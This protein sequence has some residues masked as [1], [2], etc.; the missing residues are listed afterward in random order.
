MSNFAIVKKLICQNLR[1][2][3]LD[4]SIELWYTSYVEFCM[5]LSNDSCLLFWL[6]GIILV[7]KGNEDSD[8]STQSS[9]LRHQLTSF[10]EI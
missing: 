8:N 1:W 10:G 9:K 3:V 4:I 2:K 6:S 5:N 7:W